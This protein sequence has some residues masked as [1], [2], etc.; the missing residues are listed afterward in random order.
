MLTLSLC[1]PKSFCYVDLEALLIIQVC[2]ICFGPYT[3]RLLSPTQGSLFSE[4][5][6]LMEL[7]VIISVNLHDVWL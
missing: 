3:I 2:F 4:E 7:S 5:C 1:V 6:S